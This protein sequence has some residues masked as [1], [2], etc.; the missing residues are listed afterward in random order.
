MTKV[1]AGQ[2]NCQDTNGTP[3]IQTSTDGNYL[4]WGVEECV[5][6]HTPMAYVSQRPAAWT[7][8]TFNN[9]KTCAWENSK[10]GPRATEPA[11]RHGRRRV[12]RS[13][14]RPA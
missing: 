10:S 4:P 14:A 12:L 3:G 2:V 11:K 1:Y 8:G 5:A 9:D 13:T 7:Q 6:W